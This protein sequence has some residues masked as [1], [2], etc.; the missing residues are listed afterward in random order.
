MD[1]KVDKVP[2]WDRMPGTKY[3]T[4]LLAE[5]RP[6]LRNNKL[7]HSMCAHTNQNPRCRQ[8]L[9]H[10]CDIWI[11]IWLYQPWIIF[12]LILAKACYLKDRPQQSLRCYPPK[13]PTPPWGVSG[14]EADDISSFL[15][16]AG[17]DPDSWGPSRAG[18]SPYSWA[19]WRCWSWPSW[20]AGG[21]PH[22]LSASRSASGEIL[23]GFPLPALNLNF[24]QIFC[25]R[26]WKRKDPYGGK[27][28]DRQ[29]SKHVLLST[30]IYST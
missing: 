10:Y 19:W 29:V 13:S 21:Q 20:G 1:R 16:H 5:K 30:P 24:Y 2:D 7:L 26:W 23:S 11:W 18:L 9:W 15:P 8:S 6:L 4:W 27:N 3:Y 17:T 28:K 14:K 25:S 12:W 22:H